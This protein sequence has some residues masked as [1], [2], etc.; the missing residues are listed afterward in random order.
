MMKQK[1]QH[2]RFV[3]LRPEA[4]LRSHNSDKLAEALEVYLGFGLQGF[5]VHRFSAL[6][7]ASIVE[8]RN[9]REQQG[10]QQRIDLFDGGRP[11][12]SN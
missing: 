3:P 9:K 11:W 1:P 5:R 10:A 12:G 6:G 4:Y 7:K 2:A 8:D